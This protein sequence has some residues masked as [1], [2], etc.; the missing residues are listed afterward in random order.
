MFVCSVEATQKRVPT[1]ILYDERHISDIK[2]QC[3]GGKE[4]SVLAFDKTYNL[5]TIYVTPSVHKNS[6]LCH[7]RTNDSPLFL[8][9]GHS[10]FDT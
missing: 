9:H 5:G 2:G 7:Q 3:F 6:A 1:V 8:R 4:S 10:D